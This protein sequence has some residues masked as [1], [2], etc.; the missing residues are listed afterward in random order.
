[1]AFILKMLQ[2]DNGGHHQ[3]SEVT[4][5]A[6]PLEAAISYLYW[7]RHD[8]QDLLKKPQQHQKVRY[9][10]YFILFLVAQGS[11]NLLLP[12]WSNFLEVL[13]HRGA[14][15]CPDKFHN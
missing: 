9:L 2:K 13:I 10:F 5:D 6:S 12:S 7:S 1:M 4:M 14:K 15:R 3:G 11:T 8:A